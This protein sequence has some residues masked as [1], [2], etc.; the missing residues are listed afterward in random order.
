[1]SAHA[2][3]STGGGKQNDG[4]TKELDIVL[5]D[6]SLLCRQL[7]LRWVELQSRQ[8]STWFKQEERVLLFVL[9]EIDG[10]RAGHRRGCEWDSR[11]PLDLFINQP[12]CEFQWR[13]AAPMET[14]HSS[15]SD[16]A[17]QRSKPVHKVGNEELRDT[18][19]L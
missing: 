16:G 1:M 11:S 10:E 14:N 4:I 2:P 13:R 5:E 6:G 17:K 9:V 18:A 15:R 7:G 3:S 12:P 19:A 8:R